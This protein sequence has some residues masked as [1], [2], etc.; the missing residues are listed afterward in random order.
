M[1][2]DIGNKIDNPATLAL[3]VRLV[4]RFVKLLDIVYRERGI[5]A[6]CSLCG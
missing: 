6:H 2:L 4:Q 5:S 3:T 1:D